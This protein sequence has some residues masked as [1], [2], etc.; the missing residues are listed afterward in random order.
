MS[1]PT[2]WRRQESTYIM[3]CVRRHLPLEDIPRRSSSPRQPP[4]TMRFSSFTP[5]AVAGLLAGLGCDTTVKGRDAAAGQSP[6]PA[7]A[8]LAEV[9]I[10][11]DAPNDGAP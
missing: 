10:R 6:Q 4:C 2:L 5:I 7:Q 1:N 9:T 11:L 3:G 8:H